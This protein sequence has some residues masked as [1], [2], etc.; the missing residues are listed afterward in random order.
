MTA[1]R[2]TALWQRGTFASAVIAA[3]ATA[4]SAVAQPRIANARMETRT[5]TDGLTRE[6]SALA[7]RTEPAWVAYRAP[8]VAG[9]REM[10]CYD[11]GR[12]RLEGSGVSMSMN[13]IDRLRSSRVMLEP[14]SEFLVFARV[15]NGQVGRIRTL[16]P[17]CDIDAGG[18]PVV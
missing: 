17:D 10:C 12:C 7:G 9:P 2:P 11:N 16:T 4:T 6:M 13:D 15:A 1:P 5:V 3:L 8:M 18:M 14:P